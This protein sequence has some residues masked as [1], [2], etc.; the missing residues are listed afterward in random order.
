M[1]IRY[2]IPND[3]ILLYWDYY[4]EREDFIERCINKSKEIKRPMCAM[5]GIWTWTGSVNYNKTFKSARALLKALKKS[6]IRTLT[7]CMWG[8]DGSEASIYSAL[9]GM[10]LYAESFYGH[11][12]DDLEHTK[13]MFRVCTGYN[14]DTFM[15]LDIDQIECDDS[16]RDCMPGY[17]IRANV[18][19][20]Q[21]TYQDILQGLF[22]Y[23][24]SKLD[25]I[26]EHFEK[27]AKKL[28]EA[29]PIGDL[30]Y[31][32]EYVMLRA[33]ILAIKGDMGIR[34][35]KA[36]DNKD[37]KSLENILK[38]LEILIDMVKELH[39]EFG[40]IWLK[41]NKGFGLDR[42]D[43]RFGGLRARI[44]RAYLRLKDYLE[45]KID[46]IEE[47]EIERLSYDGSEKALLHVMATSKIVSASQFR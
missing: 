35:K 40:K 34:L 7:A 41:N 9:L 38:E 1:N 22:D 17:D 26:K 15:A 6:N 8:D 30:D 16:L 39:Y 42:S 27:C 18:I 36:Y 31:L 24:L 5:G 43:L 4:N 14:P 45:G 32:R 28:E 46:K 12:E 20:K 10:Q 33:K 29:E 37:L 47:L 19:A 21:T 44:E 11:N 13:D 2:L 23:N 25:N 3:V